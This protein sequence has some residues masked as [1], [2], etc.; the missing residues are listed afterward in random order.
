MKV[1]YNGKTIELEE[2]EIGEETLDILTKEELEDT[3]ELT[4]EEIEKISSALG[5]I[6]E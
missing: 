5:D 1:L 6:D 4:D 3:K 2:P